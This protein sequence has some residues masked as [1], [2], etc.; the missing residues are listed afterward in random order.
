[1]VRRMSGTPKVGGG[2]RG[3]ILAYVEFVRT[4]CHAGMPE[5][6]EES[7]TLDLGREAPL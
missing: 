5:G 1:V 7:G 4:V 3:T 2:E 6:S